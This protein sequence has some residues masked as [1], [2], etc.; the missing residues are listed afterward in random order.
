MREVIGKNENRIEN[1]FYT[2]NPLCVM[3]IVELE[4]I[5]NLNLL[6]NSAGT[7]NISKVLK[8]YGNNVFS[9]DLVQRDYPL[10]LVE[11]FLKTKLERTFDIAV[12]NPPFKLT[13]EFI[14]KT[15]EYTDKQILFQRLQ[16]LESK[17]RFNEIFSKNYLKKVYIYISRQ[18]T[19]ENHKANSICFCWFVLDKNNKDKP[20]IVWI[21]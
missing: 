12:Y 9:I 2:T 19:N 11:D 3:D 1:D 20:I 5:K 17:K 15:W 13:S 10:D 18:I 8:Q 21:K 6:E 4:N 16:F 14:E 7:G